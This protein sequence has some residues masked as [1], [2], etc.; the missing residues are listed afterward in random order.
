MMRIP[1][2][3]FVA[4]AALL[5][6]TVSADPARSFAGGSSPA[7]ILMQHVSSSAN[8]VGLGIPGNS[9][10][11]PL[12]NPLFGG[13]S[14]VLGISYPS[15]HPI[16]ITDT[17][18]DAWP[19]S[20]AV[21]ADYGTGNYVAA[22][23]VLPRS[24]AG[25]D[26]ITVGMGRRDLPFQ[27]T[28]S[29]IC[30]LAISPVNGTK[31]GIGLAPNS[32]TAIIDPGSFTPTINNDALGG[33]VIWSYVALASIANGNPTTWSAGNGLTL[34]DGDIAWTTKQGFPHASEWQIQRMRAA[35]DPTMTATADTA[36]RFNSVSVALKVADAGVT[37]P[38]GIHINKI[39]HQTSNI[40]PG[41]WNLQ[42]PTTGNLRV[43]TLT[44]P[45][46]LT[47]ISSITDNDG[48]VW[49]LAQVGGDTPQIWWAANRP[50]N[51][52]LKLTLHISGSSPTTSPRFFDISGAAAAPF[53]TSTGVGY[54]DCSSV[55]RIAGQ[56][57]ITPS[58]PNG[59]VIATMGIGQGP[60][61]RLASGGPTGAVWDLTTYSGEVDTDLME[62]ADAMGHVYNSDTSR[63]NWSWIITPH[64]NDSCSSEAAAFR[65]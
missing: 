31:A 37:M 9:F 4:T 20:P 2:K 41:T 26:I 32:K 65:G 3:P 29:E 15:G 5:A 56:P 61:V 1:F 47:Y 33:N 63:E 17:L 10:H 58:T 13:C 40:P 8:P 18:K 46:G 30:N 22:I 21:T 49:H 54:T 60:G 45:R 28:V 50:A 62:N 42:E 27:Y 44:S 16:T 51:P 14:L 11:I 59:L 25:N 38:A 39:I 52:N 34:L 23:Y 12:P 48:S 53:D 19:T 6:L 35:V 7:P 36:D 43:L 57:I 64:P 55:A 24:L